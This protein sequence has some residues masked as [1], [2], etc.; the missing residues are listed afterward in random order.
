MYARFV[1]CSY[2]DDTY[3]AASNYPFSMSEYERTLTIPNRGEGNGGTFGFR[4]KNADTLR[5]LRESSN[6]SIEQMAEMTRLT[7]KQ[8]Q[9]AES[10]EA[11]LDLF[12]LVEILNVMSG[13][14][15]LHIVKEE[16]IDCQIV[17]TDT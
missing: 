10:A 13:R 6:L 4:R 12:D 5:T 17:C 16:E 3:E 2:R 7:R 9:D 14:L 15:V 8:I 1:D 11:G